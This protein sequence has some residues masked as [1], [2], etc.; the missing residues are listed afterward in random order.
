MIRSRARWATAGLAVTALAGLSA[1]SAGEAPAGSTDAEA[2]GPVTIE[3]W[4]WNAETGEQIAKAFNEAQGD[5]TVKY[6]L[7]ASNVAT[8][9]NFQNAMEA[10]SDVPC[11]VQGFAPLTTMVVNGW[12][13]DITA[14]VEGSADLYNE[15]ALAAAQVDGKYYGLP[16]GS[17]GQFY[18]VNQKTFDKYDVEVPTT[19]DEFVD[20][21]R[22]L[23][24]HG[25]DITNLAGEDPSSLMNLAQQAGAEWFAIDGDQWVV[26]FTDE[27]T[28]AAADVYQQLIDE[29]LVSNQTYMDKPALLKY[30]DSGKM[31]S[32]TTQWWSLGGYQVGFTDSANDWAAYP[33]PQF[34]DATEPVTPGRTLPS[35][36]P[37]GCENPDAVMAYTDWLTTPEAVEAGKNKETGAI[38][39]PTQIPDPSPYVEEVIPKGFFADEKTAG[40]VIVDAQET[41]IGKFELGPDYDA[42]F[43]ELQDQWGK[44]V[45]GKITLEE[46]LT[47]VEEFVASDLESKGISYTVAE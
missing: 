16:S 29:D 31:A 9:T 42:W 38:G 47:A 36:V 2:T 41:V 25:V 34:A 32:V 19:W 4:G 7:Q 8:Q 15:G 17:D 21:G 14:Q 35:F 40:D 20:A 27:G 22:E 5:V 1:C 23:K 28:L 33:I 37:V 12:A 24:P 46:A 18:I 43:P 10:G 44:A 39:F 6:V 11:L 13:Q 26:N 45:A 3:V 30:F